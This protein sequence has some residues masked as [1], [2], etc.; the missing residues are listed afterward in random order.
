MQ[1]DGY[2]RRHSGYY[3][4]M[5][6]IL[7]AEDDSSLRQ[8]IAGALEKAGHQVSAF[9]DGMEAFAALKDNP[10]DLLVTDIVMPGL[11]GIELS[12]RATALRP[13]LKVVFI[14]GFAA[15]ALEDKDALSGKSKLISKPFH[16]ST[17]VDEINAMLH[18]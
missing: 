3:N 12:T 7:L 9:G 8:F 6:N 18:G 5:A 11:D 4:I 2:K 1:K 16:L 14:T 13:S 10:F 17:L 15:M